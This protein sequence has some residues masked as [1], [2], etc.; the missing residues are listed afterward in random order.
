MVLALQYSLYIVYRRLSVIWGSL[1]ISND[2]SET[3][4]Y[5]GSV[6]YIIRTGR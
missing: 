5:T 2:M 4:L 1:S 3:K 6:W